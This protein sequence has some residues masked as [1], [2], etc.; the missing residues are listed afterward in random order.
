MVFKWDKIYKYLATLYGYY[1]VY[2]YGVYFY[3]VY[4]KWEMLHCHD[5]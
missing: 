4:Y 1:Y 2:F 3:G 5:I